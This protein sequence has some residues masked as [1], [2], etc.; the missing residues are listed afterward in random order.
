MLNMSVISFK[1]TSMGYARVKQQ[2]ESMI[3]GAGPS[4][5]DHHLQRQR[6]HRVLALRADGC[7]C[8]GAWRL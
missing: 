6:R 8:R 3:E 4:H 1:L 2:S 7:A 5:P